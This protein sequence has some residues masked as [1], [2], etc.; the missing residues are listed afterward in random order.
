MKYKPTIVV[1]GIVL[2]ALLIVKGILYYQEQINIQKEIKT[3]PL[4]IKYFDKSETSLRSRKVIFAQMD[5]TNNYCE[6]PLFFCPSGVHLGMAKKDWSRLKTPDNKIMINGKTISAIV[7]YVFDYLSDELESVNVQVTDISDTYV[8]QAVLNTLGDHRIDYYYES[9]FSSHIWFYDDYYIY[10]RHNNNE[11]A[12]LT[13]ATYKS[14][15]KFN[16]LYKSFDDII[17]YGCCGSSVFE[18]YINEQ[19]GGKT[20]RKGQKKYKYGDSDIYQGS[21]KQAEDLAAIDAY[22]GF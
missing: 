17:E 10:L 19:Y 1:L 7:V 12:Y 16:T 5:R 4:Q 15:F 9:L 13:V 21:S 20:G 6:N 11:C 3:Y 8:Q 14:K 2:M 18:D 22:F